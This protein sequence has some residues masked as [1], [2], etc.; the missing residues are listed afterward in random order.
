MLDDRRA[1]SHIG[2]LKPSLVPRPCDY[3]VPVCYVPANVLYS[4]DI[5]GFSPRSFSA[6]PGN[7][8]GVPHCAIFWIR[9]GVSISPPGPN[10]ML[11]EQINKTVANTC[12][13][14][15]KY[16]ILRSYQYYVR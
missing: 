12:G 7:D 16:E 6:D 4:Y 15:M 11:K 3:T 13:T 10:R 1:F 14:R 9:K 2:L 5:N 8:E